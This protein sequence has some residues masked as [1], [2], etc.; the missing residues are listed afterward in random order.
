VN[1]NEFVELV[2]TRKRFTE[3][4]EGNIVTIRLCGHADWFAGCSSGLPCLGK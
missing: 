3:F 2:E 4:T 1:F